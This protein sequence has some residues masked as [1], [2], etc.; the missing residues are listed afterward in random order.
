MKALTITLLTLL[1]SMGA[2]AVNTHIACQ[3]YSWEKLDGEYR[4][5]YEKKHEVSIVLEDTKN[6][7]FYP[8]DDMYSVFLNEKFTQSAY[9][10][11]DNEIIWD[12]YIDNEKGARWRHVLDKLTSQLTIT[13]QFIPS[14]LKFSY[15]DN[16]RRTYNCATKR[17][18][19]D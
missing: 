4:I 19:F 18:L 16:W 12:F 10:K 5:R 8:N 17:D 14:E 7:K 2:W 3:F 9:I 1:M 15:K 13:N 11:K 6:L